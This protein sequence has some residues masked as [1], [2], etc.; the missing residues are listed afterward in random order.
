MSESFI[1]VTGRSAWQTWARVV[2]QIKPAILSSVTAD[3]SLHYSQSLDASRNTASSASLQISS[4]GLRRFSDADGAFCARFGCLDRDRACLLCLILAALS[5]FSLNGVMAQG[6][7]EEG[8]T[9][10]VTVNTGWNIRFISSS[11]SKSRLSYLKSAN[12]RA[13]DSRVV[14]LHKN[15]HTPS[16]NK[17][18]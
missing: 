12:S 11:T 5:S 2:F 18:N 17:Q 3:T 4:R 15:S 1:S 13:F 7:T 6:S 8:G 14:W 9:F 16:L 10:T